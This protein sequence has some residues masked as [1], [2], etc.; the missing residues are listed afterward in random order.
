MRGRIT[1]LL[2]LLAVAGFMHFWNANKVVR[3]T[4]YLSKLEK[5]YAAEKNI[6]TELMVELDDLRSGKHVASLVRVEL[7]N[8][9]PSEEQGKVIY[10]QEPV[11]E[12]EKDGYCIIDLIAQKAQAKEV[13]VLLD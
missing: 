13:Q 12:K 8:F 9:V 10:V 5:S 1:V 2:M 6:H 11:E 7:S 3:Q 4:K